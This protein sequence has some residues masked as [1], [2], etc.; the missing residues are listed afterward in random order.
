MDCF[1]RLV[2]LLAL[3]VSTL[4][5]VLFARMDTKWSTILAYAAPTAP[6]VWGILRMAYAPVAPLGHL[7]AVAAWL[8]IS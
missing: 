8:A 5:T 6:I 7:P 2:L 4:L 1:V 3:T